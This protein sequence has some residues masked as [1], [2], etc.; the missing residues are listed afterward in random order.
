MGAVDIERIAFLDTETTGVHGGA[1][2]CPFL[3]GVGYFRGGDFEVVQYFIR[4]FHEEASMLLA[5]EGLLS[6]FELLVTYNGQSFDVPLV[7]NRCVLSRCTSPFGRMAHLDLLFMARRLWRAG[8]GSC[9]LTALEQEI[10]GFFRGPDIPGAEIPRAYFDYLASSDAISLR[11]VFS[12]HV[13]DILS[14][15]ALTIHAAARVVREPLR[16][17]D[18][19]DLYS[20]GRLFDHARDYE[21]CVRFYELALEG[22]LG[23]EVR[24]RVMERLSVLY[25][26]GG[27]LSRSMQMCGQ[28]MVLD[29]CNL[30][31]YEGAAMLHEHQERDLKAACAVIGEGLDKLEQADRRGARLRAR[32]ERLRKKS[33][34]TLFE[35]QPAP[36]SAGDGVD[37]PEDRPAAKSG[38]T[39]R[40][41]RR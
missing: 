6:A 35:D 27:D 40:P 24:V 4:D 21:K 22:G 1:G 29:Q 32:L 2:M 17:D 20:L 10:L 5:L 34:G 30:V 38:P 15:A 9:R 26:R 14:L 28:L 36:A 13:D 41:E 3:I 39:G 11:S 12:H 7:E 19:L 8:H 16:F 37:G 31:G 33:G 25:R 23:Y 18:P